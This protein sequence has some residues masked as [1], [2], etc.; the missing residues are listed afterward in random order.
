[1]LEN[2]SIPPENVRKNLWF[3]DVFREYR[4]VKLD[5]NGLKG[6]VL[7]NLINRYVTSING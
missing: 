7:L 5:Q 3:S 4:Y 2:L 6:A 1:M